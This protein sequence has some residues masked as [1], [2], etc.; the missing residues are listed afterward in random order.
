MSIAVGQI[1]SAIQLSDAD[2]DTKVQVEESSDEDKIRFD[3]GGTERM[4]IDNAGRVTMPY[5]PAFEATSGTF[6]GD[7]TVAGSET[8]VFSNARVNIGSHYNASTGIFTAP[9]TGLYHF[10]FF[11]SPASNSKTARYFRGQ[12]VKTSG[13]SDDIIFA[14][15]NTINDESANADY[16]NIAASGVV[17]LS[18]NDTVKVQFGSAI[19]TDGFTFYADFNSFSGYLIG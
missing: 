8:F 13:G 9:V 18:A 12:L 6:S 16:N 15:H 1:N 17:S 5:Q 3:T 19:A 2:G 11:L 10:S 7:G 4:A 14:P